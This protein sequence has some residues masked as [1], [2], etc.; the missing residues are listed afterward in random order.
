MNSQRIGIIG[1]GRMGTAIATRLIELG[2]EVMV[3]NRTPARAADATASGAVF[4]DALAD[5]CSSTD[6]L[7]SSLTDY[8]AL[9]T[10]H[11]GPDGILAQDIAGKLYIEMSTLLPSQQQTLEAGVTASG[12]AYVECPVGGTVAPALKGQLLGM[13]GGAEESFERA[14]P[15]LE[16]LCKRVERVG[17]VGAGSAMKLAVNLPLAIYWV[18]L[19]EAMG[20]L[21]GQGLSGQFVASMLADSSAGPAVLKNRME[22]IAST[23]D[24]KDHPGTFDINGLRKDLALSLEWA[25]ESGST[26]SITR[27]ALTIYEEA[28]GKGLG[29]FDGSSISRFISER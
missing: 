4:S 20:V 23:L 15:I 24:G 7:I 19:G 26:M 8:A 16:G 21:K 3:W 10:V 27:E 22:V 13:C 28:V 6:V 25:K 12:C 29:G 2:Y 5:L 1:T 11:E 9:K 17:A 18:T 14:K